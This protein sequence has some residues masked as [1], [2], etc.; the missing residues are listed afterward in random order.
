MENL[1]SSLV[2]AEL[3]D[4]VRLVD[5]PLTLDSSSSMKDAIGIC[6]NESPGAVLDYAI[7]L[8]LNHI[9][10]AN[11]SFFANEVGASA[12]MIASPEDFMKY[13]LSTILRGGD[14]GPEQEKLV[15]GYSA[16]FSGSSEKHR[17]LDELST[18]LGSV[19]RANSVVLTEA[20]NIADELIMNAVFNAPFLDMNGKLESVSIQSDEVRFGKG[21]KA[22]LFGG[23]QD[24]Q[25]VIGCSDEYG[26][27]NLD[28]LAL[29]IRNCVESGVLDNINWTGVGGA[30]IG[31]FMVYNLGISYYAGVFKG[32]QSVVCCKVPLGMSFRKRS[33]EPKNLH[34]FEI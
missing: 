30:G 14:C 19:L 21:K 17:I 28:R 26:T 3:V 6:S 9:C 16:S 31:S 27:L 5:L 7:D 8:K 34:F 24:R 18:W 25:L 2:P 20:T 1:L 12:R 13:P 4:Q 10:Q 23:I 33:G 29:K 15:L 32:R 11:G 22:Y